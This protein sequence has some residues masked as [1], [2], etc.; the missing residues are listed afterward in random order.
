VEFFKAKKLR[1]QKGA[2][3]FPYIEFNK[4][5]SINLLN[6]LNKVYSEIVN[7]I[8]APFNT[9]CFFALKKNLYLINLIYFSLLFCFKIQGEIPTISFL[10][11]GNGIQHERIQIRG[12]VYETEN[13]E[14]ILA[15]KPNLKSCCIN[16]YQTI[17][18]KGLSEYHKT[19]NAM[20]LEGNLIV[21]NVPNHSKYILEDVT[22]V[23]ENKSL[24]PIILTIIF[25]LL[26]IGASIFIYKSFYGK[27]YAII[28]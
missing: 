28:S 26:M 6:F 10:D 24:M 16:T 8:F 13:K 15:P 2:K 3:C 12:F 22:V 1:G 20:K 23:Q 27:S 9:L 5:L 21:S 25:V 14:I 4:F 17:I 18:V 19:K 7:K 11:L